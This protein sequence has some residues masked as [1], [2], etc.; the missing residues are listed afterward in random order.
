MR[1]CCHILKDEGQQWE[2]T[3]LGQIFDKQ[4]LC[5]SCLSAWLSLGN[6][7]LCHYFLEDAWSVEE[8]LDC[9]ERFGTAVEYGNLLQEVQTR[10]GSLNS[11]HFSTAE[12]L[13]LNIYI[14]NLFPFPF[15]SVQVI[16]C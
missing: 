13:F 15:Q 10:E 4:L 2:L 14:H 7:E 9:P 12:N 11:E 5:S 1:V 16:N 6:G 3:P 8:T